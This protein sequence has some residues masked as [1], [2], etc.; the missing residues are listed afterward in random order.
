[1]H[2]RLESAALPIVL[3]V[4]PFEHVLD[5]EYLAN[6]VPGVRVPSELIERMRRAPD[7]DTAAQEGI[8]IASEITHALRGAVQGVNV[9]PPQGRFDQAL[10]LLDA[11]A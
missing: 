5:A 6:E 11:L 9:S 2:R 4:R 7:A 8:A 1:M 3:S 10:A